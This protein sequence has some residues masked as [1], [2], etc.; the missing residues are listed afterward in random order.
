[1]S[2][3]LKYANNEDE[4]EYRAESFLEAVNKVLMMYVPG[5]DKKIKMLV[6]RDTTA[7]I[8]FGGP[9]TQEAIMDVMAHLSFY[10]KYFPKTAEAPDAKSPETILNH[11]RAILAEDREARVADVAPKVVALSKAAGSRGPAESSASGSQGVEVP[12]VENSDAT[13]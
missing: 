3:A 12:A 6:G 8:S 11:F 4:F 13:E 5:G 9:I 1:M 10:K 7:E 2:Q